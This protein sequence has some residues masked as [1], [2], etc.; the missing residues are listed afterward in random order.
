M[1]YDR[2]EKKV[3]LFAVLFIGVVDLIRDYFKRDVVD[4]G[5]VAAIF[6]VLMPLL[7]WVV[8][9]RSDRARK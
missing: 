1:S 9:R 4:A 2:F 7:L 6:F 3:P 5:V 8:G